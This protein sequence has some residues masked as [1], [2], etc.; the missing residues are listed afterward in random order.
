MSTPQLL[1]D[2]DAHSSPLTAADGHGALFAAIPPEVPTL[3]RILHG[4]GI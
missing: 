3:V 2:F 1:L 4:L